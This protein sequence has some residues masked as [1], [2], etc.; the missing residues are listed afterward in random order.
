MKNTFQLL[1]EY[2]QGSEVQAHPV[3]WEELA[4]LR[5]HLDDIWAHIGVDISF[6]HHFFDRVNDPRNRRQITIQELQ[7]LFKQTYERHGQAIAAKVKPHSDHEFEA[8]LTD[9]STKVNLPFVLKWDRAKRELVLVAKTVMRKDNFH[10]PDPKLTVQHYEPET[11]GSARRL[12]EH[13]KTYR[14]LLLD[15]V[16][17]DTPEVAPIATPQAVDDVDTAAFAVQKPDVLDKLN[18]YCHDIANHQYLNPYYPLNKLW[19]KLSMIGLNFDLNKLMLVGSQGRAVVPM[20]QYGGRFGVLGGPFDHYV[21]KDDGIS[22]RLPGGLNL[23]V[24][25]Q[26]NS[27][28]YSLDV[29]IERGVAT[30]EFIEGAQQKPDLKKK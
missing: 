24:T 14:T 21:S 8:V 10:T 16:G 13:M 17:W 18:A 27:G 30:G 7:K 20:T 19:Q 3:T 22:G 5:K 9:L 28:V 11:T 6:S 26:K 29:Q 15:W 12:R 23:V 2:H 1:K 4:D 25:F